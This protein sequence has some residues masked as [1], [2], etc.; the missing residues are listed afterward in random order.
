MRKN[1][2]PAAKIA[3]RDSFINLLNEKNYNEISVKEIINTSFINKSTFYKYFNGKQ[4]LLTYI[5]EELLEGLSPLLDNALMVPNP[6][7][8]NPY[9]SMYFSYIRENFDLWYLLTQKTDQEFQAMLTKFIHDHCLNSTTNRQKILGQDPN[10]S[11]DLF[12]IMLSSIY[13]GLF[14]WWVVHHMPYSD[15]YMGKL[16]CTLWKRLSSWA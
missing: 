6:F 12:A 11:K 9:L 4:D 5:E 13:S 3:I 15:E 14:S 16:L 1:S 2:V 7:D 8:D 10:I